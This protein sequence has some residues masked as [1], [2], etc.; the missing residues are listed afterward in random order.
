MLPAPTGRRRARPRARSPT[1]VCL[2][3]PEATSG[4]EPW[5]V[6]L[7][8]T[9]RWIVLC[10]LYSVRGFRWRL[11]G[12]G[13]MSPAVPSWSGCRGG[14]AASPLSFDAAAWCTRGQTDPPTHTSAPRYWRFSAVWFRELDSSV[15]LL[16]VFPFMI[17]SYFLGEKV[18]GNRAS[19]FRAAS[20]S[21]KY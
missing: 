20:L 6:C 15:C 10:V 7:L 4:G 3:A 16:C 18:R 9:L 12:Q 21:P 14:R 13:G 5:R 11:S 1:E 17:L 8:E 19:L 2:G